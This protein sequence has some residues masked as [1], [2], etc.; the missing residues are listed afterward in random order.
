MDP[1]QKERL[2]AACKAYCENNDDDDDV[3][4][5]NLAQIVDDERKNN[6]RVIRPS[7]PYSYEDEDAYQSD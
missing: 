5:Q 7:S 2:K 6:V 4:F 1:K 3:A